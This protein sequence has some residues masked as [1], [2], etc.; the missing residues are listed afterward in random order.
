VAIRRRLVVLSVYPEDQAG[1]RLRAHQFQAHL[2]EAGV[3]TEYWSFLSLRDSR[4]WFASTGALARLVILGRGALRTLLLPRLLGRADV[5][6]VLR[7]ALPIASAVVERA[8]ARRAPVVWDVDDAIWSEYP[9]LF[10]RW[11]PARLRL[12]PAKYEQIAGLATE[13]WAGSEMLAL[14]CR[15][16]ASDVHVVPTVLDLA[17]VRPSSGRP[18]AA[19]W[20]GSASTV[21]FLETVLPALARMDPP[22]HLRCVG[23]TEVEA[24]GMSV[25]AEPWTQEAED[26]ALADARVGLYPIDIDHP[27]GPGKAGLK[28]VLYMAHGVPSVVTP[29]ET[30]AGLVRDGVE[31]FHASTPEQWRD[32]VQRLVGDDELWQRMAAAAR[33]RAESHYSLGVWG[34][35]VQRRVAALCSRAA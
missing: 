6:L 11:M 3:D 25:S 32:C 19:A 27:L 9:R 7:E 18:H 12:S 14:W 34:P 4:R 31:G 33:S 23:A 20:V 30:V 22:L 15:R 16:R 8:A 24:E 26:E 28:A 29:T 13:V 10:A 35:W 5:V 1:T 17:T 21:Q 2:A